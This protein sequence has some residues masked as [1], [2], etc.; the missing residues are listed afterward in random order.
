V[1]PGIEILG[2]EVKTFG[3]MFA[4]GWVATG[5]Y[6]SRRLRE[7]G[8]PADWTYE[9]VF[10]GLLGGFIGAR[11]Y[12]LVEHA[13]DLDGGVLSNVFSG[14]GLVWYGGAIGGTVSVLA[15][16]R[17]R[18]MFGVGLLDLCA[19]PLALGQAIGRIGCQLSGD[20]DY[21]RPWDGP[22]AMAY[23]DGVV[24]TDVPVHP[25]PLYETLAL[26]LAAWVLWR[27]RDALRPGLAFALYLVLAGAQRFLV[28]FVRR[29]DDVALGLTT[30]QLQ[31]LALVL[32]GA[33]WLALAARRGGLRRA[34]AAAAGRRAV[35][36]A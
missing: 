21:G 12:W 33:A 36:P 6:L 14:N 35:Q 15:W 22:W 19:V 3:L 26:G 18:G 23:P 11:V 7:L 25:T 17:W 4:L 29:N 30:A 10:A 5:I 16:A 31:S 32:A 1:Q 34:P 28:E 13:G 9:L 8:K 24:P 27:L 20:G 2:L